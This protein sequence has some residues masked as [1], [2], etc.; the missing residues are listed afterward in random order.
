V[1]KLMFSMPPGT[2]PQKVLE[3]VRNLCREEFVQNFLGLD[4]PNFLS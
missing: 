4:P 1:H 3:A 2:P